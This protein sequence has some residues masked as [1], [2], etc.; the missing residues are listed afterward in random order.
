MVVALM[1]VYWQG[2]GG[3]TAGIMYVTNY[4]IGCTSM[5][6]EIVPGTV[7]HLIKPTTNTKHKNCI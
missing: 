2:R 1:M 5:S 3:K 4:D 6:I 7:I